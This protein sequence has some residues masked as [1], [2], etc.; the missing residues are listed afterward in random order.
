MSAT[1]GSRVA[2]ATVPPVPQPAPTIELFGMPVQVVALDDYPL[3]PYVRLVF[4]DGRFLEIAGASRGW[5][6][7]L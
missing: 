7:G 2:D 3:G 5:P 6:E 1:L 4:P